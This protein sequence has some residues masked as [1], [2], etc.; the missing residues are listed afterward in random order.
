VERPVRNTTNQNMNGWLNIFGLAAS[1]LLAGCS[2]KTYKQS[3]Q[4]LTSD[5]T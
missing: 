3:K 1:V 5:N 2:I 4:F